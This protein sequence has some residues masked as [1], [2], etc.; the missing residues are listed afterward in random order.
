MERPE[1]TVDNGV[2]PSVDTW[3]EACVISQEW[4]DGARLAARRRR[5]LRITLANG[6]MLL[7]M[8]ALI[9]A[10]LITSGVWNP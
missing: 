3:A 2:E 7:I 10:I 9:A 5:M 1:Y 8:A 6:V 4:A